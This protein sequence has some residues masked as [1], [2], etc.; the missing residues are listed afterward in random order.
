MGSSESLTLLP[1]DIAQHPALDFTCPHCAAELQMEVADAFQTLTAHT[2]LIRTADQRANQVDGRWL[3]VRCPACDVL[4]DVGI[5]AVVTVA[6]S[7]VSAPADPQARMF[8]GGA[9]FNSRRST[10][11]VPTVRLGGPQ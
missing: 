4:F 9:L 7:A 2:G 10:R 3:R 5:N 6:F 1:P 11:E 8:N